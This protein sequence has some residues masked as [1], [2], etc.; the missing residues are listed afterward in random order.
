MKLL[1]DLTSRSGLKQCN[2]KKANTHLLS[3]YYVPGSKA[4]GFAMRSFNPPNNSEFF[5]LLPG[6][7][8]SVRG[9]NLPNVV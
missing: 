5:S 7:K 1:A 2:G 3:T 4:K 8:L 9:G 6:M